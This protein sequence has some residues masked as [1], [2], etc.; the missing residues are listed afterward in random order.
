MSQRG[1]NNLTE[2]HKIQKCKSRTCTR[3]NQITKHKEKK[4]HSSILFIKAMQ[5]K[6]TPKYLT[7]N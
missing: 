5:I 7:F 6:R 3:G 2:K 4:E 1:I